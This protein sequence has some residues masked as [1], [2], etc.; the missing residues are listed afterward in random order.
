MNVFQVMVQG[1]NR[2]MSFSAYIAALAVS[3]TI[4]LLNGEYCVRNYEVR[5]FDQKQFKV[6]II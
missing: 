5:D 4:V 1:H 3:D 6:F 2:H